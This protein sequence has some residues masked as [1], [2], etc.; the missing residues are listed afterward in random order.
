MK[1]HHFFKVLL[2]LTLC[3]LTSTG[4]EIERRIRIFEA[5]PKSIQDRIAERSAKL[6]R[7][8]DFA[9]NKLFSFIKIT[10]C[11]PP[12]RPVTVAF[13]GGDPV[14]QSNIASIA[15]GWMSSNVNIHLDFGPDANKGI[16]RTWST[17]DTNFVADVR[18]AFDQPGYW[19]LIGTE[20]CDKT[21]GVMPNE[22]SLNL[23]GFDSALPPDWAG[24]VLHEFG[25][26]LGFMHEHQS[27]ANNCEAEFRWL[28][29]PKYVATTNQYGEFISYFDGD[30]KLLCPGV[31][32][33]LGGPPNG[34][35]KEKVD[36]N[37]RRV[38]YSSAYAI[39]S[40]DKKSIMMYTFDSWMYVKS[41][42]SPCFTTENTKLS[43]GDRK[44]IADT[45]PIGIN[46]SREVLATQTKQIE[47]LLSIK[48]LDADL[49]HSYKSKLD[50]LR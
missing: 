37:M 27:P 31:Y 19:S 17:T 8:R 39:E 1:F 13:R 36:E 11:W 49:K 12:S 34:W 48:G 10:S 21:L 25:H 43:E 38:P 35:D 5:Y 24:L 7:T 14:L 3:C 40:F 46:E 41:D 2:L 22:T 30:G 6:S 18:V 28:D 15:L 33:V 26:A 47:T 44:G 50:T 23:E 32:T 29:D 4:Q 42:Q 16:F 9:G 20:S 45:Y